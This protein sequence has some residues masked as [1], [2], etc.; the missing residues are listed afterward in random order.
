[1]IVSQHLVVSVVF[2]EHFEVMNIVLIGFNIQSQVLSHQFAHFAQVDVVS[3]IVT[4]EM[5]LLL[6][7]LCESLLK[8]FE[9]LDSIKDINVF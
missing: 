2:S 5:T 1:M 4:F 6:S 7:V 3:Q 8:L 9:S